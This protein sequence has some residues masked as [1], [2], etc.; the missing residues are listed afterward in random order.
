[1]LF[2]SAN[3]PCSQSW[4]TSPTSKSTSLALPADHHHQACQTIPNQRCP[5]ITNQRRRQQVV[6]SLPPFLVTPK[7]YHDKRLNQ[8]G[9][10]PKTHN[11]R[12]TLGLSAESLEPEIRSV[13][14][15]RGTS[16]YSHLIQELPSVAA[17][18]DADADLA[19]T[20]AP[21][22]EA[23]QQAR[24]EAM[25]LYPGV[26][27]TLQRIRTAGTRIAAYTE[28]QAFYTASRLRKLELDGVIDVLFSSPDHDLPSGVTPDTL[29]TKPAD[30]YGLRHT[31]HRHTPPGI[32]KPCT[33]VLQSIV[34]DLG[35]GDG[36]A[37]VG[38][39]MMK[40]VAMAQ[41][42]GVHDVFASYGQVH[43]RPGYDLLRR[44]SHWTEE[45]VE[46]EREILARPR[47]TPSVVLRSSFAEILDHFQFVTHGH[48]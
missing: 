42:V 47:V 20:Y 34:D 24:R 41:A 40:D 32:L 16:E 22:I 2:R 12:D 45:D 25:R 23:A 21:A 43:D 38:D 14:Q 27:D 1:M 44:V 15:L 33:Q 19:V 28:S 35:D 36:I 4:L 13:H 6:S 9:P 3:T 11:L 39:S 7:A 18:H 8:V 46:R 17:R 37:Y 48:K 29:R 31:E 26:K 30:Q 5:P 10:P